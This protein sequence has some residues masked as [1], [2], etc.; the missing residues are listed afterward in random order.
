MMGYVLRQKNSS[1][2]YGND[3]FHEQSSHLRMI[4]SKV[5]I[6]FSYKYVMGVCVHREEVPVVEVSSLLYFQGKWGCSLLFPS[7][8]EVMVIRSQ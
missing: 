2:T 5:C 8:P 4:I 7:L 1:F 3:P 6:D